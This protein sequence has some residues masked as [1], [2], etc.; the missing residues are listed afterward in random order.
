MNINQFIDKKNRSIIN[1]TIQIKIRIYFIHISY[2]KKTHSND[3]KNLTYLF[4]DSNSY[5]RHI[6][7]NNSIKFAHFSK[8]KI[9]K[10]KPL[11]LI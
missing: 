10:K 1:N 11:S 3:N 6:H 8:D 9:T 5:P 2:M 4:Y 7:T